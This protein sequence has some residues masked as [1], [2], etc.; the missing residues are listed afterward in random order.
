SSIRKVFLG[1]VSNYY[2]RLSVAEIQMRT[3]K[4]ALGNQLA[5]FGKTTGSHIESVREIRKDDTSVDQSSGPGLLTIPVGKK[6]R[7]GDQVYVL[8]NL[9]DQPQKK[10]EKSPKSGAG[11]LQNAK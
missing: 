2:G 4:V 8:E 1:E 10:S 7:K 6:V 9:A 11:I 5:F 3:G